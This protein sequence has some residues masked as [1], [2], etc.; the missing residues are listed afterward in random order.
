MGDEAA[1]AGAA[2]AED[3]QALE[4]FFEFVEAVG[5]FFEEELDGGEFAVY[6]FVY[7][8][9]FGGYEAVGGGEEHEGVGGCGREEVLDGGG[10]VVV[11]EVLREEVEEFE[12]EGVSWRGVGDDVGHR[13]SA[14]GVAEFGDGAA[15][16]GGIG[17]ERRI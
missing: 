8:D 10:A 9:P 6:V 16:I 13:R 15:A 2:T 12:A 4:V 1:V 3:V 14:E 11:E 7:D 5:A 17:V